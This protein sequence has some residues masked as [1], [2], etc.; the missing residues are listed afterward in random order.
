[1][2]AAQ[3]L[4]ADSLMGLYLVKSISSSVPERIFSA[5]Y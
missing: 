5:V 3:D 1:M 2:A 4:F